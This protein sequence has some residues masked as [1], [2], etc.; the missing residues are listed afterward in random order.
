[1]FI[2]GIRFPGIY[3]SLVPI[4]KWCRKVTHVRCSQEACKPLSALLASKHIEDIKHIHC[5]G[6]IASRWVRVVH[7]KLVAEGRAEPVFCHLGYGFMQVMAPSLLASGRLGEG[8]SWEPHTEPRAAAQSPR[9]LG[10][11]ERT[12]HIFSRASHRAKCFLGITEMSP[13]ASLF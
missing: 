5:C 7:G 11:R 13:A 4:R 9:L 8:R 3:C 1:M 10:S 12:M 2:S 6:S